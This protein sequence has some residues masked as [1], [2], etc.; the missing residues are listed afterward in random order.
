MFRHGQ[1]CAL[2]LTALLGSAGPS[3]AAEP[4]GLPQ[5][6][7]LTELTYVDSQASRSGVVLEAADARV[8]PQRDRLPDS[9]TPDF[10]AEGGHAGFPG[11]DRWMARRVLG[12]LSAA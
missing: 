9:V 10:P 5:T 8:L 1:I 2:L 4:E 12:F 3:L 11:A 7:D 6:L